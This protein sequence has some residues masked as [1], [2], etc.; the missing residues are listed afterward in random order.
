MW[1]I[2]RI[3]LQGIILLILCS[4]F[5]VS[6][7]VQ[8]SLEQLTKA[9]WMIRWNSLPLITH[10]DLERQ[11]VRD[12]DLLWYLRGPCTAEAVN[13]C[14][15]LRVLNMIEG[16]SWKCCLLKAWLNPCPRVPGESSQTCFYLRQRRASTPWVSVTDNIVCMKKAFWV[17]LSFCL[18]KQHGEK[19][20]LQFLFNLLLIISRQ[21]CLPLLVGSSE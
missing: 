18:T 21:W 16:I 17:H 15:L 7:L 2:Y 11:G 10:K 5:V 8:T 19:C 9:C 4:P 14:D 6:W 20:F 1:W 12:Q 3:C 13:V